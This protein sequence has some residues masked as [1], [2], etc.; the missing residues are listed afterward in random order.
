MTTF[1]RAIRF[2]LNG[3]TEDA[4]IGASETV[5]DVLQRCFNLYGARESCGQGLCG[6]CTVLVDGLSD[7]KSTR[8]INVADVGTALNP[9]IAARQLSGAALMQLSFTL[10]ESMQF[11]HGQVVN[12][13]LADYKIPG[14]LDVPGEVTNRLVEVP[15]GEGPF[16]AKGVGE[17]GTFAV[18]PAVANAVFD[19]VG[20]R[21]RDL[22]L[23]PEV[24][25]R[26]LCD[27]QGAPLG[28]NQ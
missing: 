12:A 23:T 17:S 24:V 11:E 7:R 16:G 10:S 5:L 22:P 15:H 19:A 6:C 1:S 14:M 3:K 28:S 18:S 27:A 13:S 20:V 25:F 4:L 21:I 26:A 8:L 2:T 9:S